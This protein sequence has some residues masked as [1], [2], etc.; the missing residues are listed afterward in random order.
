M[1]RES[2]I[3][4]GDWRINIA[5]GDWSAI[6]PEG[7]SYDLS[8]HMSGVVLENN[9]NYAVQYNSYPDTDGY[10]YICGSFARL[11]TNEGS[12][13]RYTEALLHAIR[14][15]NNINAHLRARHQ[16]PTPNNMS[17]RYYWGY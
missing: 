9:P 16:K 12:F 6:I 3:I 11:D 7:Y 4:L 17:G 13:E 8:K 5:Y 15:V 10:V 14:A 1:H 2:T